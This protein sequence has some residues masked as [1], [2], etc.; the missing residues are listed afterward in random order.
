MKIRLGTRGSRLALAQ[1]RDVARRLAASGHEAEIVIVRTSG[2][3]R[4]DA[5]FAEIGP[6]GVFVVELERALLDGRVDIA[7]H[8]Y[9]DVPSLSPAGLSIV[10][11]PER[12]D[13]RDLLLVREASAAGGEGTLPLKP[14]ATIG[15]ASMRRRAWIRAERPD[16]TTALLRGNL[17]T[18]IRRLAEGD[19]DAIVLAAAGIERLRRAEGAGALPLDGIRVVPLDPERF[20]PAPSQGAIAVQ[21]RADDDAIRTAC[22]ALDDPAARRAVRAERRLLEMVEGGCSVPFGAYCRP[23]GETALELI[24]RLERGGRIVDARARGEDPDALAA[25]VFRRLTGGGGGDD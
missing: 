10:A 14:G 3:Q 21:A 23:A 20:V 19:F 25:E 4:R 17:P 5:P 6:A 18:R 2:D 11:V 24:A 1:A 22:E 9:K 13:P 15:T 12:V 16:L 8:S 7:V